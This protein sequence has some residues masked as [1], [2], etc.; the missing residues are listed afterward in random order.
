MINGC[1]PNS[2][3]NLRGVFSGAG[4]GVVAIAFSSSIN[5]SSPG[6][7]RLVDVSESWTRDELTFFHRL[8]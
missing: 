7:E 5:F 4:D 6:G 3:V 1:L 8:V 2:G